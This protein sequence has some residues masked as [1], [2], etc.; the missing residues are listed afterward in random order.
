M[1]AADAERHIGPRRAG[2]LATDGDEFAD[3]FL[4]DADERIG[5]QQAF[6]DIDSEELA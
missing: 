4:I 3:A 5:G 2:A 6:F 1:F